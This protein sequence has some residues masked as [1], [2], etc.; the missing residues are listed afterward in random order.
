MQCA[1]HPGL[2][3]ALPALNKSASEQVAAWDFSH[4]E[5]SARLRAAARL[6]EGAGAAAAAAR[7][8]AT[9]ALAPLRA[10]AAVVRAARRTNCAVAAVFGPLNMPLAR[11]QLW[12]V[13]FTGAI[14]MLAVDVGCA[15]C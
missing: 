10:A 11:W 15:G 8:A 3:E 5:R 2:K 7:G 1:A 13:L 12:V 6:R 9:T 4:A 14:A